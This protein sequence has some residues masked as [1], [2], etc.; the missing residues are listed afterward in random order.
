MKT[1]SAR[2]DS[3][4]VSQPSRPTSADE[5]WRMI[6]QAAYFLANERGFDGGDPL[7]DWLAAE[8]R[9]DAMLSQ[10]NP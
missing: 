7:S 6:A 1:K 8:K 10:Q 9:V 5:R 3:T 4:R 2:K